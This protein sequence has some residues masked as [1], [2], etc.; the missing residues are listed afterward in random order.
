MFCDVAETQ[1]RQVQH[2]PASTKHPEV[3][4]KFQSFSN[5]DINGFGQSRSVFTGG[6]PCR[7]KP[8]VPISVDITV[9]S[10]RFWWIANFASNATIDGDVRKELNTY[11]AK[12]SFRTT[13]PFQD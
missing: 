3:L 2:S 9:T 6:M 8:Q 11:S 12:V 1:F 5:Q 4:W 7:A 10:S 13:F